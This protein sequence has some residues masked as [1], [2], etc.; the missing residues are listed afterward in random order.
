MHESAPACRFSSSTC[1]NPRRRVSLARALWI[2][3]RT[4]AGALVRVGQWTLPGRRQPCTWSRAAPAAVAAVSLSVA[5]AVE[6]A[7]DAPGPLTRVRLHIDPRPRAFA[8]SFRGLVFSGVGGLCKSTGLKTTQ[9]SA[10]KTCPRL[11]SDLGRSSLGRADCIRGVYDERELSERRGSV[12][13]A[14]LAQHNGHIHACHP[15]KRT[16]T[17]HRRLAKNKHNLRCKTN[18]TW[19]P[20][21]VAA[22]KLH[23]DESRQ[24][25]RHTKLMVDEVASRLGRSR[26]W[27]PC[28]RGS[29]MRDPCSKRRRGALSCKLVDSKLR[30][31]MV[32][33][34]AAIELV[35][36]V[37][38]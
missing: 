23:S 16:R 38:A 21:H 7:H 2:E 28:A 35:C 36:F 15:K 25:E 26:A 10:R 31:P 20:N 14:R 1:S 27:R 3:A 29:Y 5:K 12:S 4:Q 9:A 24:L 30:R 22:L 33:R 6:D 19:V 32:A 37:R 11:V 13:R 17:A 8:L 34:I 18:T